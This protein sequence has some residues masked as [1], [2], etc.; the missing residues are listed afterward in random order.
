MSISYC[1]YCN[2]AQSLLMGNIYCSHQ[3]ESIKKLDNGVMFINSRKL[4][5]TD[6]HISRLSI[7]CMTGGEQYYKVGSNEHT[8]TPENYLV[9]N[10]GQHYKTSYQGSGNNEMMLMAF[11]PGFAEEI[12][13]SEMTNEDK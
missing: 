13:Y 9:I 3:R 6:I 1:P 2:S 8:V 12:L 11:K 4:E 5:E 7:R 10:Q